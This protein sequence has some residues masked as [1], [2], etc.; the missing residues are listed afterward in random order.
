[1]GCI[2]SDSVKTLE[3]NKQKVD[4]GMGDYCYARELTEG[5]LDRAMTAKSSDVDFCARL[6]LYS[7]V[8]DE[9]KNIFKSI[10]DVS[11]LPYRW[12]DAI[13]SVTIEMN[14]TTIEEIEEAAKN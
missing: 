13:G 9:G 12:V 10:A 14:K 3:F 11:K 7:A 6:V 1:M 4:L 8:D 2:T 5:E